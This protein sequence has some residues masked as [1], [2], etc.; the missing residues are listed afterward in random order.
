[1][2]D[3][4]E[5]LANTYL[6]VEPNKQLHAPKAAVG[7]FRSLAKVRIGTETVYRE[8]STVFFVAK[9]LCVTIEDDFVNVT[10]SILPLPRF[11][12][13]QR[14]GS[15]TSAQ[16][17]NRRTNHLLSVGLLCLRRVALDCDVWVE[18]LL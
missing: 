2:A 16:N 13:L 14:A 15:F 10:L 8:G 11:G 18:S 7:R 12:G 17:G 3:Q 6:E 5:T 1:M 4:P 9:V